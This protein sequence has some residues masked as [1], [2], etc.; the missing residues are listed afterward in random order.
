MCWCVLQEQVAGHE[1][2]EEFVGRPDEH[3]VIVGRVGMVAGEENVLV[4]PVDA[5]AVAVDHRADRLAVVKL[6]HHRL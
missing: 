6:A 4:L 3:A 2:V 5:A 1:P